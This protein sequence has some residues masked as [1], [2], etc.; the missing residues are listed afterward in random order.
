MILS[1]F[2]CLKRAEASH[3][4]FPKPQECDILT[5]AVE[6]YVV[7]FYVFDMVSLGFCMD[8][9]CVGMSLYVLFDVLCYVSVCLLYV[10]VCLY[11]FCFLYGFC[12]VFV[13]T[14]TSLYLL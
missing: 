14:G 8:F 5:F 12:M 7:L 3:S 13:F 9:V 2:P 1:H 4:K 10:L 11:M 6:L